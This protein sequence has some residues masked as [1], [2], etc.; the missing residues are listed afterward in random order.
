MD[1]YKQ[2]K[3]EAIGLTDTSA[4]KPIY[5]PRH[6]VGR[7]AF[8]STAAESSLERPKVVNIYETSQQREAAGVNVSYDNSFSA[9]KNNIFNF[10]G[11]ARE[12]TLKSMVTQKNTA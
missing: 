3:A 6:G 5:A 4:T 8:Q 12:Q 2:S 1:S 10:K 9:I 11:A 7:R